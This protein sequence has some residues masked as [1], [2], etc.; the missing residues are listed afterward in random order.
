MSTVI[1]L[2]LVHFIPKLYTDTSGKEGGYTVIFHSSVCI[3]LKIQISGYVFVTCQPK[4]T[5]SSKKLI[6]VFSKEL[7]STSTNS[8]A[9]NTT[10]PTLNFS[11][12]FKSLLPLK[13]P[14]HR[15]ETK[16]ENLGAHKPPFS[17]SGLREVAVA[18][19]SPVS[20]SNR[21]SPGEQQGFMTEL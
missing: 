1:L 3:R 17:S 21:E 4:L 18:C 14:P 12:L 10:S 9:D 8:S 6:S 13:Q 11:F 2:E 5:E 20:P 19:C 16:M 7:E 15:P